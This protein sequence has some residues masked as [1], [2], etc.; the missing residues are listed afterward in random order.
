MRN[1]LQ[2]STEEQAVE[3]PEDKEVTNRKIN[4]KTFDDENMDSNEGGCDDHHRRYRK[5][6]MNGS[7]SRGQSGTLNTNP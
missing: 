6:G 3:E 7:I 5:P 4:G 1:L 2:S